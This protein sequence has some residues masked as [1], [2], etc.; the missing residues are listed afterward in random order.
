MN[1]QSLVAIGN[2]Q[3]AV[4]FFN[5]Q[6]VI[7]LAMMDKVHSRPDGTA[8]RNF[9]KNKGKLIENE[10]YF[11][12][13]SLEAKSEFDI[14]APNGLII[15][16]ETG[17]LLLVKSFT[18]DLAWQIQ[19]QLV[20]AYFAVKQHIQPDPLAPEHITGNDLH[21]IKR[22]IWDIGRFLGFESTWIAAAWYAIRIITGTNAPQKFETRH[23]PT[24]AEELRR[25]LNAAQ[26]LRDYCR[27]PTAASSKK[28]CS[29]TSFAAAAT[30]T[31]SSPGKKPF[32][33]KP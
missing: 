28:P 3:I 27:K 12:R 9:N 7:T 1:T 31:P 15:L 20:K 4:L 33:R 21:N 10:D 17:Y 16:T 23:L 19:R 6:P 30:S 24:I 14:T 26:K 2:T 5:G 13:N 18:D 11:Q 22:T 32:T 29:R 8:S 25:H